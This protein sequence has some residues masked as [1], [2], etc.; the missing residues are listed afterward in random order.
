MKAQ[1]QC[2]FSPIPMEEYRH[3]AWGA[4]VWEVWNCY[5]GPD[6]LL[7]RWLFFKK[8]WLAGYKVGVL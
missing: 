6:E 2:D 7:T 3:V 5:Y 1:L 8:G 4:F